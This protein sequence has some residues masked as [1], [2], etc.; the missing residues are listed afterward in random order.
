MSASPFARPAPE[1]QVLRND[2]CYARWD[3]YP[4]SK[5]HLLV[6]PFR[7]FASYFDASEE[8]KRALWSLVDKAKAHLDGLYRPAGYNVGMNIGR[9]AG[10][11]VM[12]MHIHVIPRYENDMPW[13]RGGVR[14]V[15]PKKRKYPGK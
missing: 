1:D 10:Q 2:L 4:V 8:E 13:P 3:K 7:E 5:G 15:I 6:I 12:H 11:T 14:G 9:A